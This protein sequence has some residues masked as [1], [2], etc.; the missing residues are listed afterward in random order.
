M[1]TT[2]STVWWPAGGPRTSGRRLRGTVIAVVATTLAPLLAVLL[3]ASAPPAH[4]HATLL[5]TTPAVDGAVADSPDQLQLVFDQAVVP[6][7]SLIRLTSAG[8][9]Q[10]PTGEPAAGEDARVLIAPVTEPLPPGEYVVRWQVTAPDGDT[11]T[12]DFRF[13]VGSTEG[14]AGP[15][16]EDQAAS[17]RGLPALTALRALM[18]VGL[19]LALGGL[20]GSRHARATRQVDADD[21]PNPSVDP[22]PWVVPGALL[23]LAA[24]TALGVA[25]LGGGSLADGVTRVAQVPSLLDATPGRLL[26]VQAV[27]FSI[28][29]LLAAM[30]QRRPARRVRRTMAGAALVAVAAAE[31]VRSHP[32]AAAPGWG[33][34]LVV[35]HLLAVA[36][37]TGA[38]VHVVRVAR[39]R[40]R[41]G[42]ATAPV[43]LAYARTALV[44]FVLVAVTGTASALVLVRPRGVLGTLL[45]TSYGRWLLAKLA[46]VAAVVVLA[47]LAR[48]HLRSRRGGEQ[49]GRTARLEIG[50]LVVVLVVSALLTTL[51]PPVRKD[52]SLPFPPP[53]SGPVVAVG[54]RAGWIG[55][56]ATASEGQLVIRLKTPDVDASL[57]AVEPGGSDGEDDGFGLAANVVESGGDEPRP[58]ELRRCGHGCFVAPVE[59]DPG[60]H[61][62]TVDA[63]AAGWG[64]GTAAVTLAWP[65]RQ[66]PAVL[67]RAVRAMRGLDR[68]TVYERVTSD[69]RA[70]L[71]AERRLGI[72]GPAFLEAE[73]YGSGVAPSVVVT[74]RSGDETEVALAY[75]GEGVYV[76]LVLDHHGR[77][78][79]ETLTTANHL[80]NR[81]F[82]YP[83]ARSSGGHVHEH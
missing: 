7:G 48:R 25:Q 83:E 79:R 41:R 16:E 57:E 24:T 66:S 45:E 46:L 39:A 29:A 19:C 34:V 81:T 22:V 12:G 20:V 35:V 80:V 6:T 72:S 23:G 74:G 17:V 8:G 67:R 53:P 61:T 33:A 73:P 37:W 59:W 58:L 69:T 60:R 65:P 82:V 38:L 1:T 56:G 31:G 2:R 10:L 54:G 32:E 9:E 3:L 44:L 42:V 15:A 40:A 14:L 71:G 36:V 62:V 27:A 70:G 49:P 78:V 4:A 50:G 18:F 5:F 13:G 63:A 11:M 77:V 47:L 55:V 21:D 64:S 76:R 75:P 51:S 68:F 30:V 26:V 43:V 28:A 52:L